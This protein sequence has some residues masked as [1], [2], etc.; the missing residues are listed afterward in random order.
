MYFGD[1]LRD[2]AHL[3]LSEHGVYLLLMAHYY[4]TGKPLPAD[5]C[6]LQRI[7]RCTTADDTKALRSVVGNFFKLSDGV[8]RHKRIDAEIARGIK[9]S[10]IQSDKARRA[11][12]AR[13][14]GSH[15]DAPGTA[16]RIST[17]MES[18]E[19]GG[20]PF[21]AYPQPQPHSQP[22]PQP[23][24]NTSSP[25]GDVAAV[26][27]HWKKKLNHPRA[28]LDSKRKKCL[29]KALAS[30]SIE[31]CLT[32][33][34]GCSVTPHNMG[35]NDCYEVYDEITLIL[36]DSAHIE[37]FIRNAA[38]PPTGANHEKKP[39]GK[40]GRAAQA[41]RDAA[42][43]GRTKPVQDVGSTTRLLPGGRGVADDST[44]HG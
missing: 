25:C 22:Q 6:A 15:G 35:K 30:Y 27:D 19:H 5:E 18:A 39:T 8:Y 29:E 9:I 20:L 17:S 37:R 13:W 12:G 21:N 43:S 4:S 28:V 2:T 26:F 31:Q 7:C 32:A 11:A 38:N 44:G 23:H 34:D 36:R 3:S 14:H 24:K 40:L 10:E 16:P 33:I 41:M 42:S 1:Y